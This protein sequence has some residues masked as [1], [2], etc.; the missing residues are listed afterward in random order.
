MVKTED[1]LPDTAIDKI[2]LD[3][4]CVKQPGLF[5]YWAKREV[6]HIKN[7]DAALVA[8]KKVEDNLTIV[9]ARSNANMRGY[10]LAKL[11]K[12]LNVELPKTPDVA[13]W[14]ELVLLHPDVAKAQ[15]AVYISQDAYLKVKHARLDMKNAR[16]SME[17]KAQELNNLIYLHNREYNAKDSYGHQPKQVRQT[18]RSTIHHKAEEAM[19]EK[20]K[21][22][23]KA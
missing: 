20:L 23:I 22:R 15:N 14:K 13:L 5:G 21:G 19:A 17:A 11:N 12:V 2:N 8:L 6:D 10:D 3:E 16:R 4:E 9:R 7:E 1:W 18:H